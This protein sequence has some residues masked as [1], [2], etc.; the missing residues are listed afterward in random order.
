MALKD[1]EFRP[2]DE[3]YYRDRTTY[4][5]QGD[6]FCGI[7]QGYT[8]PSDAIAHAEG[9]RT[10]LSG[11]FGSGFGMLV[12]PTCSMLAQG[13]ATGYAHA[14]RHRRHGHSRRARPGC[15]RTRCPA[16]GFVI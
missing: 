7:P 15:R 12:T 9:E 4:V 2:A 14:V 8:W 16:A 1:W 5:R 11:P 13:D 3:S 6:L 10:F